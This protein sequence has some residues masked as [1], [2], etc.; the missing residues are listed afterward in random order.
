MHGPQAEAKHVGTDYNGNNYY[1]NNNEQFGACQSHQ[2]SPSHMHQP[3]RH[4]WVVYKNL[5]SLDSCTIPPEWHR[6]FGAC[7]HG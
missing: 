4:R 7:M 5:D 1:E 3:G 2:W 6:M